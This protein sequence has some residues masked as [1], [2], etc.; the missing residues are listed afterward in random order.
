MYSSDPDGYLPLPPLPPKWS[1]QDPDGAARL[2]RA[3]DE[4][5]GVPAGFRWEL[6]G[7]HD[8]DQADP[9]GRCRRTA[10]RV[11]L[12]DAGPECPGDAVGLAGYLDEVDATV[13]G[14]TDAEVEA[15]L[16]DVLARACTQPHPPGTHGQCPPGAPCHGG[17]P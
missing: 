15:R 1:A 5:A 17:A 8:F 11:S 3:L 4:L 16:A 6:V 2:E 13:A 7:V 9:Q 14:I 12:L 10:C